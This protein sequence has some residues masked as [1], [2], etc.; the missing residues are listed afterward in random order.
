MRTITHSSPLDSVQK[1]F[2]KKQLALWLG[3]SERFIEKEVAAGRLRR[4]ILGT[5]R[6]RFLPQ[7]VNEWLEAHASEEK[8]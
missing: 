3:C 5:H 2:T 6:V 4:I 8:P 7:H 1:P